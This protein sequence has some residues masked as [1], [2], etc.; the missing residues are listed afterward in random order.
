MSR[1][2][3]RSE[4]NPENTTPVEEETTYQDRTT[5]KE[6]PWL[7]LKGFLMGTAD[8]I[9]GVSGGTM[10]LITGIYDRLIYAIKSVDLRL[11]RALLRFRI[12]EVFRLFHWRFV[13]VLLA[14]IFLAVLFFT[15]VVPLHIYMHTAP[16]IVYGLFFGLI[17]GS[18]FVLLNELDKGRRRVADL[19]A[20]AGG[21]AFGFMV[22]TLVPAET[23]NTFISVFL[24][25][26]IAFCAM[27]LP[28]ISGSYILLIL[29]KYDYILG[30]LADL[31]S[32]SVEAA[33]ALF[34]LFLGGAFGLA[35]FSRVLTWLLRSWYTATML[36]LIGFLIGSLYA[37][38]PWQERVY[39][40]EV[41]ATEVLAED[42]PKL[43]QL[44]REPY[45]PRHP[46]AWRVVEKLPESGEVVIERVERKMV[47]SEPHLPSPGEPERTV[48]FWK[49]V[50]GMAAGLI[51]VSGIDLLRR[52][53]S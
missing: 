47:D 9:P 48:Y 6:S 5:L 17:A 14:G 26:S 19:V 53:E 16:E 42:D 35:L 21:T 12:G 51:L 44:L 18:V 7:A 37:I 46:D 3:D 33:T 22:V 43:L 41:V 31:G 23:P 49:G 25:G 30:H 15:Q 32:E 52:K 29:G 27:I 24:S 34:P 28:G 11:F 45:D 2:D 10:A 40:E 1:T 39:V 38:W 36:V 50:G 13:G 8:I 20:L 4:L